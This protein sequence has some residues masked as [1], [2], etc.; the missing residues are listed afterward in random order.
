MILAKRRTENDGRT[1]D[2]NFGKLVFVN[3]LPIT[4]RTDLNYRQSLKEEILIIS[5][6][7]SINFCQNDAGVPPSV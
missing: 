1:W 2:H 3:Q 7:A 5:F 4:K 6:F